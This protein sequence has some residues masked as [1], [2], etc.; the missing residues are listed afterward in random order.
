MKYPI[1]PWD[2]QHD[3][4]GSIAER[5]HGIASMAECNFGLAGFVTRA[6]LPACRA[7]GL[8]GILYDDSI[9]PNNYD[10]NAV[11]DAEMDTRMRRWTEGTADDPAVYGYYIIDEPGANDF[12][13]L[14]RA[15]ATLKRYAPDKIAYINLFPNYATLGANNLSQLQ[16]DTFEEYVERF[17][18][19]VNPPFISYDNYQVQYSQDLSEPT[20]AAS[21]LTNLVQV[22][23]TAQRHR[24]PWRQIVSSNQ[25]RPSSTV[26]SPANLALQAYTSLAAGASCVDWYTYYQRGYTYAPVDDREERSQTWYYLAEV[27]RQLQLVG[28]EINRLRSTGLYL[29]GY[30]APGYA[31]APHVLTAAVESSEP[32][33]VG[34]FEDARGGLYAMLVNLSLERSA[35]VA[36]RVEPYGVT[37]QAFSSGTGTYQPLDHR[38]P[39]WM[40]A[41]SGILVQVRS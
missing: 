37:L 15:V 12:P 31:Q 21:Y 26:P 11:S 34:T 33:M 10:W 1:L 39:L 6:D 13:G 23:N 7:A 35:K 16:V 22:R 30:D 41:G 38:Q 17:A 3:W 29:M 18:S 2:P 25:I 32:L 28:P 24:L 27:N 9:G 19:E 20:I 8:Q 14:A 36:F 40:V 5:R 4:D